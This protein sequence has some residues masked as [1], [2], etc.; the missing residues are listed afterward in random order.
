MNFK[1][2]ASFASTAAVTMLLSCSLNTSASAQTEPYFGDNL[3]PSSPY[4]DQQYGDPG[5]DQ[6]G[7]PGFDQYG[8]PGF[9]QYGDPG[10]DQYGNPGFDQYGNPGFSSPPYQDRNFNNPSSPQSSVIRVRPGVRP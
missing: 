7:D 8:D 6:Y 2:V 1:S 3:N 4:E 9:D 5:F 10:F